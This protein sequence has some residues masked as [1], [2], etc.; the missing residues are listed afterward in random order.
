MG[1]ENDEE[2]FALIGS[3]RIRRLSPQHQ[4]LIGRIMNLMLDALTGNSQDSK[5]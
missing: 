4:Q 5:E 2:I 3:E 1:Q